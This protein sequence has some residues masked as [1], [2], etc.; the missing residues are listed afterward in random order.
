MGEDKAALRLDGVPMAHVV[1]RALFDGGAGAVVRIGALADEE[2]AV[3]DR[4][5]GEGPLG[6]LTT[7]VAHGEATEGVSIILVAACDQPDLSPD[8]LRALIHALASGPEEAVASAART[9]DGRLHPF[10]SAWRAS[11]ATTL[12]ALVA[13]G[14]RRADAAFTIGPVIELQAAG[15][16]LTDLDTPDDVRRWHERHHDAGCPVPGNRS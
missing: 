11:A 16:P 10:P 15:E 1:Q 8:L 2:G 14:E 13:G 5:P 4:W 9:P 12:L 6:G 3:P 7:A